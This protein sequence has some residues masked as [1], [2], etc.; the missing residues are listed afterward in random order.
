MPS[1]ESRP[2]LI[3]PPDIISGESWIHDRSGLPEAL[4][5]Q[6]VDWDPGQDVVLRR[7]I[8]I[9][10]AR[11][12]AA[13]G[14][15]AGS[16]IAAC[17]SWRS[18]GS[19]QRGN[20]F[21]RVLPLGGATICSIEARIPGSELGGSVNVITRIV[22]ANAGVNTAGLAA[23]RIGSILWE[24]TVSLV[25]EG[26]GSRFPIEVV[27]FAS[28]SFPPNA[29]WRLYWQPGNLSAQAMGCFRLLINKRHRR[30]A[31]AA[32]RAVP[33]AESKAIWSAVNVGVARE[34][35]SGAL[36]ED[37]FIAPDSA[38]DEGSV[39]EVALALLQRAFPGETQ[40]AVRER[41]QGTP[42]LF[43]CQLQEAFNLFDPKSSD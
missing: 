23:F 34:I 20:A 22:L 21:R 26:I 35:I 43:E 14:L 8:N 41:M 13:C 7:T 38:F 25:L 11:A 31:I 27:D 39:G 1:V 17:V 30:M 4:P 5:P 6:L 32:S 18:P 37:A 9:D 15:G 16:E 42:A 40:Q 36:S 2:Y 3:C 24:D 33:D 12:E 28:M 10:V 29:A 19:G